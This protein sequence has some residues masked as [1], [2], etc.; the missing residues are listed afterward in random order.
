M[1]GVRCWSPRFLQAPVAHGH[2]GVGRGHPESEAA[3]R[4]LRGPGGVN[5]VNLP[6]RGAPVNLQMRAPRAECYDRRRPADYFVYTPPG[7]ARRGRG[8]AP[9]RWAAGSSPSGRRPRLPGDRRPDLVER[10]ARVERV[11]AH[12]AG[13]VE[14]PDGEVGHDHR[15]PTADP[16]PARAGSA[17]PA[18]RRRGCRARSGS[19]SSRRSE[20]DDWRMITNT[21]RA[22]I[23]ISHAPPRPGQPRRRGR[24]VADDRR[25]DV[26]EPV[27]LRRAEEPD[28]DQATAAGRS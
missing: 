2:V 10:H 16:A 6:A 19:R 26:A 15:R 5:G 21:W 7:R 12:L 27:D 14:V 20:R 4:D 25:V 11:D 9:R 22:L 18:R 3:A 23:A 28:V 17:R 1:P 8:A 24:V 13:L